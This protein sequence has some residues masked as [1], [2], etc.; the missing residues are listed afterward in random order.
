MLWDSP[1]IPRTRRKECAGMDA[2]LTSWPARPI[3]AIFALV[4]ATS[5]TG[6]L[7]LREPHTISPPS[8]HSV[9]YDQLL[10]RSDFRLPAEHPIFND[11][12]QLQYQLI[13]TLKLPKPKDP[14]VVYLFEDAEPYQQ[15]IDATFPDLPKRRAYFVG[16]KYELGVYGFW[17]NKVRED[18]RHEF[19]HGILHSS[20]G[21]VPLWLDEGLAEYFEVISPSG[22]PVNEKYVAELTA[23]VGHG[24]QPNMKRL[25]AIED[26][27]KLQRM[28]YQESWAWM[29]FLLSDSDATRKILI[30]YVAGLR[31]S[32]PPEVISTRL[33]TLYPDYESRLIR[34]LGSL[35]HPV[36]MSAARHSQ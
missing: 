27:A 4:L 7:Q 33:R 11:L 24:W 17:G 6:C 8:R 20:L 18:L 5:S 2:T 13:D 34:H 3:V 32:R 16:S 30:D 23:A 14:V 10:V 31:K 29:H 35:A 15:Y 9:R 25:E 21:E 19:T 26:F 1:R 36:G 28:D 22:Q 12:N